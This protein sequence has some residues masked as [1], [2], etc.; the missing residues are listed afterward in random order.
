ME[1]GSSRSHNVQHSETRN[2]FW[3]VILDFT[4]ACEVKHETPSFFSTEI[5]K[6]FFFICFDCL[7]CRLPLLTA[8]LEIHHFHLG[9]RGNNPRFFRCFLQWINHVS[10]NAR[11]ISTICFED[12]NIGRWTAF[13]WFNYVAGQARVVVP[14]ANNK[15]VGLFIYLGPLKIIFWFLL[16]GWKVFTYGPYLYIFFPYFVRSNWKLVPT[17]QSFCPFNWPGLFCIQIKKSQHKPLGIRTSFVL[18]GSKSVPLKENAPL[19]F[20]NVYSIFTYTIIIIIILTR[21]LQAIPLEKR[22]CGRAAHVQ[23]SR[24]QGSIHLLSCLNLYKRKTKGV[25]AQ[26]AGQTFFFSPNNR[27]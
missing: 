13:S 20:Q 23:L 27:W 18:R 5:P 22:K 1:N 9:T 17:P 12:R 19:A 14:V 2:P 25:P 4:S 6:Y 10:R 11:I 26:G 7:I 3:P 15:S 21:Q 8:E 24:A 16:R